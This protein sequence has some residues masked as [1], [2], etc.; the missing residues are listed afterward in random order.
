MNSEEQFKSYY[1]EALLPELKELDRARKKHQ[2]RSDMIIWPVF[3][4][5]IGGLVFTGIYLISSKLILCGCL[6][7]LAFCIFGW[8]IMAVNNS[9]MKKTGYYEKFKTTVIGK[10]I[11]FFPYEIFYNPS[12]CVE[13]VDFFESGF[14][15]Q[16][17]SVTFKG[18]DYFNGHIK[19]V[20]IEMSE[21]SATFSSSLIGGINFNG[22]FCMATFPEQFK[23]NIT[24]N[25][26][27]N[28]YLEIKGLL[29]ENFTELCKIPVKNIWL[30]VKDRKLYIAMHRGSEFFEPA[31]ETDL[32]NYDYIKE[33]FMYFQFIFNII[34][35]LLEKR[36]VFHGRLAVSDFYS[37]KSTFQDAP[38]S[39]V[40]PSS[41]EDKYTKKIPSLEFASRPVTC[42]SCGEINYENA[43]F[44]TV[45]GYKIN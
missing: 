21:I 23:E 2:S 6:A 31:L 30:S 28:N 13:R 14:F 11:N 18:D 33:Q 43:K 36:E 19:D 3:F 45:C 7:P 44:C 29:P 35:G 25:I 5:L 12:T 24:A 38:F 40:L 37:E 22:F 10:I 42:P 16:G 20:S 8:I 15:E 1:K 34:E 27:S 41:E 32:L 17:S 9:I 39:H 26:L 4:I